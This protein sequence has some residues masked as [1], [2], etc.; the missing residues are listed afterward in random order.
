MKNTK[1]GLS[2]TTMCAMAAS[3]LGLFG[4]AVL[5]AAV[6]A[7]RHCSDAIGYAA[8]DLLVARIHGYDL[9]PEKIILP[10]ELI[11]RGSAKL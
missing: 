9:I 10:C 3:V 2:N 8:A 5:L 1:C 4:T 7:R 6:V 11:T